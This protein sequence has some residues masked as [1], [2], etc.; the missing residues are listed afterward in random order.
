MSGARR[1]SRALLRRL[2]MAWASARSALGKLRFPFELTPEQ[3]R[4]ALSQS[5]TVAQ[6]NAMASATNIDGEP[7]GDG[8]TKQERIDLASRAYHAL[9]T[10]PRPD[11][12][13]RE[14]VA[15]GVAAFADDGAGDQMTKAAYSYLED[16]VYSGDDA[17]HEPTEW[18]RALLEDFFNGLL[19]DEAFF[20][21]VRAALSK[22]DQIIALRGASSKGG[23]NP[24]GGIELVD[25]EIRPLVQALWNA[26]I[27]TVASCSGHGHRPGNIALADGREL[28]IAPDF[29][30][31][32]Q[33]DRL[34]PLDINGDA[35]AWALVPREPINLP[36]GFLRAMAETL[37]SQPGKIPW[38]RLNPGAQDALI[39]TLCFAWEA[40]IATLGPPSPPIAGRE[41]PLPASERR[42]GMSE[43]PENRRPPAGMIWQCAA[44]GKQA[45]DLYGMIGWRSGRWDESCMLNAV[46][47]PRP[48]PKGGG[49]D[50]PWSNRLGR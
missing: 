28:V 30:T 4:V 39:G 46:A 23:F 5:R 49:G 37:Q 31:A 13:D 29:E 26:G 16:Y 1:S 2:R 36:S 3:H 6:I 42:W 25:E 33:I 45:E 35:Q 8:L 24:A 41:E 7:V 22:A 38:D 17:D 34:F 48:T 40:A 12:L 44:C 21:P 27:A 32:R 10:L 15:V 43:I 19:R 11:P 9:A 20:G 47:I 50:P 14:G 18:E